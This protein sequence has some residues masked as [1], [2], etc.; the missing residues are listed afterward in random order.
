VP[1]AD[2]AE[3]HE[4]DSPAAEAEGVKFL[5]REGGANVYEV[6]SGSYHFTA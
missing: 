2:G 1:A 6:Q 4:G 3:V 5:R